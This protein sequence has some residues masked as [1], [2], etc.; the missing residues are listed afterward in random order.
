MNNLAK[1]TWQKLEK[2]GKILKNFAIKL[3]NLENKHKILGKKLKNMEKHE[4]L[5]TLG[6]QT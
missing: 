6:K 1:K 2:L 4:K 3:K 5:E